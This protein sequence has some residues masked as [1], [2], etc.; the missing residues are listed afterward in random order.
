M[1]EEAKSLFKKIKGGLEEDKEGK[2]LYETKM[3]EIND[4]SI[5]VAL[6]LNKNIP[7]NAKLLWS[8]LHCVGAISG[9]TVKGVRVVADEMGM[10]PLGVIELLE[11]LDKEGWLN[12]KFNKNTD[13]LEYY[14]VNK[15]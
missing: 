2:I 14:V 10:Y 1:D 3:S 4:I 15:K 5:P 9:I 12:I 13:M 7:N 6:I 8:K 11:I